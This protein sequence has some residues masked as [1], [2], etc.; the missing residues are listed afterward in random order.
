MIPAPTVPAAAR[1]LAIALALVPWQA[2]RSRYH[3]HRHSMQR[4]EGRRADGSGGG[5]TFGYDGP[6]TRR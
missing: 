3:R 2:A 5:P 6:T 4:P 1:T